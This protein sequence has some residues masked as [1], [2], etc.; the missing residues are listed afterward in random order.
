MLPAFMSEP[1]PAG[2]VALALG[3]LYVLWG[4]TYFGI[5][6]ALEGFPPLLMSGGRFFAA[7]TLLYVVVRL[8]GAPR[9]SARQWG[10]AAL[11]GGL[12]VAANALVTVAERTVSSSLAAVVAAS[13]PL[14]AV[15]VAGAWGEWP[16]RAEWLG[17][18]V[19]LAGVVVL[20]A[21]GGL[22]ASPAG[23]AVLLA[24]T[25]AWALGSMWSRRLPMPEGLVSPAAQMMCGGAVFLAAALLHGERPLPGLGWRPV[26]AW[27]YL[28]LFGSLVGY[29]SF[30]YLLRRVRPALA[31]SYAYV[32]P[33]VA[34]AI[35]AVAGEAVGLRTVAALA[36]ILAGVALVAV[37]R[38]ARSA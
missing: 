1:A 22:R 9:P 31:T 6:V 38:Q 18:V 4:T 17:L 23:A 11:V 29:V 34:V 36:L 30:N 25:W 7:G 37:S 20:Q 13:T 5:R 15:L 27:F 19:G 10:S 12:L 32:N 2:R 26:V 35:G 24:S 21:G 28:L 33:A 8:R 3:L 16:R 14:W